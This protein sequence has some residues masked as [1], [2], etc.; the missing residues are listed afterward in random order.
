[1]CACPFAVS[2]PMPCT[3]L[4]PYACHGAIVVSFVARVSLSEGEQQRRGGKRHHE[5]T[6]L[7]SGGG[8]DGA[9][10]RM[11]SR[12]CAP[13]TEDRMG[14][15]CSLEASHGGLRHLAYGRFVHEL[16]CLPPPPP[17]GVVSGGGR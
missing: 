16:H 17:G 9:H 1:M 10:E 2:R 14:T 7:H 11:Q 3:C 12:R 13:C 5:H 4:R 6:P 8:G 15:R